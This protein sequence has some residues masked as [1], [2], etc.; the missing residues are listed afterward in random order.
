MGIN[1]YE[2][3]LESYGRKEQRNKA[4]QK[5]KRYARGW[6]A[7]TPRLGSDASVVTQLRPGLM[8]T[9]ECSMQAA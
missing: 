7:V 6:L 9:K 1:L 3:R 4:G 8:Y 2:K 5:K